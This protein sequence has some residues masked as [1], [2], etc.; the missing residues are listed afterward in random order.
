A[1]DRRGRRALGA[2]RLCRAR[3]VARWS[4]ARRA[5]AFQ[6]RKIDAASRARLDS[7]SVARAS[8][9]L[10]MSVDGREQSSPSVEDVLVQT[11][12]ELGRVRQE[13]DEYKKLVVLL[14]EANERLKRGLL[15]QKA[16]RLPRNDSQLSLEILRMALGTDSVSADSEEEPESEQTVAEHTRKK[17]SRKPIPEHVPRVVI[18]MVPDEVKR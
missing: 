5:R 12:E 7:S 17:P 3:E 11:T 1:A 2:H 6:S 16:E 9:H 13:R 14:Q 4:S 15:G 10:V 8:G 18:E